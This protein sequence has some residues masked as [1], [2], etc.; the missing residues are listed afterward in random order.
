MEDRLRSPL[1]DNALTCTWRQLAQRAGITG[2]DPQ[3]TGFEGLGVPVHYTR[4]EQVHPDCPSIIIVPC[5]DV[6]WQALLERAPHTLDWLPA[7]E[8]A[9]RGAH[10]PFDDPL[11]VLF[12]GEGFEDSS[13]PFAKLRSDGTVVFYADIIAATFFMLSRWEEK[14]V[15][16]IDEHGRFPAMA[17]VAYKQ[18]FLDR[19][20]VDEYALILREWLKVLVPRWAP[21]PQTFSVRLSY[22]IDAIKRFPSWWHG[23]RTIGGDLLKRHNLSLAFHSLQD[24]IR[25]PY[26]RGIFRLAEL[27]RT[28]G[29]KS[30]FYFMAVGPSDMDSGYDVNSPLMRRT[31]NALQEQGFE[32]GLHASYYSFNNPER[33]A[34]E[35]A[36]L[37]KVLGKTRYGVRQHYLRFRA[38][39]TWRHWEQVGFVYDST[40]GYA[41]HEGFRC[42]TCYPFRPFDV[43]QNR[44]LNLWELP[45]I[46]MDGTLR[47]YHGFTPEQGEAR[48]LELAQRCKQVG[49]TFTLLW[50]NTS[51]D[52]EWR[53]WAEMYQRVVGKLAEMEG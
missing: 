28:Y 52:G 29:L 25:S 19:P 18:G 21:K 39:D 30:A 27:S 46:V 1:T 44:E 48:I 53:P 22:D 5:S 17:S 32:I 2:G 23:L 47:W 4:P 12:W 50:H 16:E 13:K 41:D 31:I 7:S 26:L 36:R 51:L 38:P 49:G 9:P 40:V 6:T 24:L 11:P 35:K 8:V 10:L 42:G 33:L 34:A 20:I 45:L 43:E 37:D 15:P 3:G 14:A